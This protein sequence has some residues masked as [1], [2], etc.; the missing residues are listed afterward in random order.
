MRGAARTEADVFEDLHAPLT[1][2]A[3]PAKGACLRLSPSV[4]GGAE[5][6][7]EIA[8]A[9]LDLPTVGREVERVH[10]RMPQRRFPIDDT[11]VGLEACALA[12]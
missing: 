10:C 4:G 7:H 3:P 5:H 1:A 8:K 6:G 12:P 11:V 9:L 2:E